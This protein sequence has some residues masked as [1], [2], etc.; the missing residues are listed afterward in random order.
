MED[1]GFSIPTS[2]ITAELLSQIGKTDIKIASGKLLI[3]VDIPLLDRKALQINKIYPFLMYQNILINNTGAVYI[4]PKRQYLALV[5]DGRKFFLADKN[6]CDS[7][8]KTI[9]HTHPSRQIFHQ[10]DIKIN[11][12]TPVY[13]DLI[14]SLNAWIFAKKIRQQ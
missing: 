4:I 2:H 14:L 10:C 3:S 12:G 8:Q 6:Y 11:T 5:K 9:Y 7:C 13:W 1:Y